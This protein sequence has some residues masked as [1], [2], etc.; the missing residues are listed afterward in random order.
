[1]VAV[2]AQG[3]E[4]GIPYRQVSEKAREF[5][6]RMVSISDVAERLPGASSW[7]LTGKARFQ[8]GSACAFD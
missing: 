4:E 8:R 3:K 7:L 1:M 2:D 5:G 6:G